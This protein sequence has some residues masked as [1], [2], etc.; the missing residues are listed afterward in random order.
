MRQRR[1]H[2][3]HHAQHLS[4]DQIGHRRAASLVRNVK[5]VD[6][7]AAFEHF[8]RQPLRP[9]SARGRETQLPGSGPGVGNEF[10]QRLDR[11]RRV[12]HEHQRHG[13][14]DCNRH[15]VFFEAVLDGRFFE[16]RIDRV[17][18]HRAQQQ[19]V[20]VRRCLGDSV[21]ADIAAGTAAVVDD[22]ALTHNSRQPLRHH[23]ADHVCGAA[24]REWHDQPDRLVG[25]GGCGNRGCRSQARNQGQ[26][27]KMQG[28]T[29]G[30]GC[31]RRLEGHAVSLSNRDGMPG[32]G[33]LIMGSGGCQASR[34]IHRHRA[35][36]RCAGAAANASSTGRSP[37]RRPATAAPVPAA[38][39][40][41][42]QRTAGCSRP[43]SR[44]RCSS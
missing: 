25:I 34:D 44:S 20:A 1:R 26:Q 36:T 38:R 21:R 14:H 24:R 41:P 40:G 18:G 2:C 3:F 17:R 16:R 13:A 12:N 37:G 15:Q 39:P 31:R 32:S 29:A 8:P 7:C 6:A 30:A 4:A 23:P 27:A 9:A 35:A 42:R 22:D 5:H 33:C 28:C 11:H 43:R 19:G 10:P